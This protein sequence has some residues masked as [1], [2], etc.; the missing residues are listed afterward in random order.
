MTR[1][2]S[3]IALS[4]ESTQP[5]FTPV[6]SR[7]LAET[8]LAQLRRAIINGKLPPG[9]RLIETDLADQ[10]AVSRAT[11]RQALLQLRYEGL[12]DM[13]PRRGA[14]VTRMSMEAAQDVCT[15]RGLLEGWAARVACTTLSDSEFAALR[16]L[17]VRMGESLVHENV[18]E[19]V[20]H[21]ID[22]HTII[23]SSDP[24]AHLNEH[25]Q[26]L[27]ALHGA[28]MSSQLAYYNYD[29]SAV[30]KLH[31][32]LCDVLSTRDPDQAQKAVHIHYMADRRGDAGEIRKR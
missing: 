31:N 27:N 12:V 30:V 28:L 21:D 1:A 2:D 16:R 29:P 10:F 23:C 9:E 20:E 11:I 5:A 15:V 7:S 25:W 3:A 24:N 22:F 14:L 17:A 26:S 4:D 19:A 18:Y 8:V 13:R 6:Q 32:D